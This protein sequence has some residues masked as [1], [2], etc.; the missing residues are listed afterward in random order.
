[1]TRRINWSSILFVIWSSSHK[2]VILSEE[3][4]AATDE[5]K[6]CPEL[7]EGDPYREKLNLFQR[8]GFFGPGDQKGEPSL[9]MTQQIFLTRRWMAIV[10]PDDPTPLDRR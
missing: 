6:A 7:V 4:A 2:F 3:V 8:K 5:S 9:R 10:L 1:M